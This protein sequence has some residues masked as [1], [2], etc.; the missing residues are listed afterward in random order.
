MLF[1]L[2]IVRFQIPDLSTQQIRTLL[3]V[4]LPHQVAEHFIQTNT[5][6]GLDFSLRQPLSPVLLRVEAFRLHSKGSGV[7]RI[8]DE[9]IDQ[10]SIRAFRSFGSEDYVQLAY[11]WNRQ[12][13]QSGSPYL[14][15]QRTTTTTHAADLLSRFTFGASRQFQLTNIASFVTQPEFPSRREL[16]ISPDLRWEHSDT[17]RTFYRYSLLTSRVEDVD[18][19]NQSATVGLNHRLYQSL[20]T[21]IDLHGEDNRTTGFALRTYGAAASV[22]Y[23]KQIPYGSLQLS[24]AARYDQRDRQAALAQV[25]VFGE[26]QVL[27]GTIPVTLTNDQVIT[28][29]VVVSNAARTQT[30]VEGLDYRLIL[31]GVQTR[32]QRLI[33]G[34]ILDGETVLVDYAFQTGGTAAYTL[35]DQNYQASL[36]L[37]RHLNLFARFRNAPQRLVSGTPTLPLN[38][39]RSTLYG[40][41][42]DLPLWG[43]VV[44]GEA[45]HEN[46]SEDIAPFQRMSYDLFIQI[47][48]PLSSTLRVAGR[49]VLVDNLRS[50]E[51]I[52]LLGSSAVLQSYPWPRLRVTAEASYEED[53]GGAIPRRTLRGSAVAEWRIRQLLLRAEGQH[54]QERQGD[55]ERGRSVVKLLLRREF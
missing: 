29:T 12:Q 48:L 27:S 37:F 41:S 4:A 35:F 1:V 2:I 6:Y 7:N 43:M 10:A 21:T 32:I 31:I 40:V 26:R 50:T 18:T 22:S 25:P 16:R 34:N 19:T 39:V 51:D 9:T 3:H 20:F 47:P 5:R 44:G 49:R 55:F 24:Y 54:A 15:I 11:Q 36:N 28:S 17:L 8:V 13:S 42:V 23:R 30:F 45:V 53:T 38:S 52:D 14:P 33:G 46:Q